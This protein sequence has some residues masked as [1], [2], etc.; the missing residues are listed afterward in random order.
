MDW[1][2]IFALVAMERGVRPIAHAGGKVMLERIDP[3]IVDMARSLA[4]PA[5]ARWLHQFVFDQ[6]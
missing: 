1:D 3:A 2:E 6:L 5:N 4:N